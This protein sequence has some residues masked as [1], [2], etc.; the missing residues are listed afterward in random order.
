M[1]TTTTTQVC[2]KVPVYITVDVPTGS[3]P[4]QVRD[5]VMEDL[6]D[7]DSQNDWE[8]SWD[9]IKDVIRSGEVETDGDGYT[10][11]C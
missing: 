1:T 7:D 11:T 2:I 6:R 8:A 4:E 3:T 10:I 9:D 5:A